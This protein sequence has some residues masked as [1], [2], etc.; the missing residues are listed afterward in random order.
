[1]LDFL[2]KAVKR[3]QT[4]GR[5]IESPQWLPE[6]YEKFFELTIRIERAWRHHQEVKFIAS[7]ADIKTYCIVL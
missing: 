1:M 7:P 2:F 5:Y 3:R 6:E 4:E